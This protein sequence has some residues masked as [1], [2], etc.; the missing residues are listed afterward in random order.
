MG[1]TTGKKRSIRL[2]RGFKEASMA[3][4][5]QTAPIEVDWAFTRN[6]CGAGFPC[7]DVGK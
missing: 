2:K 1:P 6:E 7:L 5:S 3:R 4:G